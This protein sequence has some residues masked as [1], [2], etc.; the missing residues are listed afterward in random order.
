[1]RALTLCLVLSAC[2]PQTQDLIDGAMLTVTCPI[3]IDS[4]HMGVRP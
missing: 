2:I 1:M 4:C 3:P